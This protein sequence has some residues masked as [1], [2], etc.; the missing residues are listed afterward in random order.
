LRIPYPIWRIFEKLI[1]AITRVIDSGMFVLGPQV[2]TLEAKLAH[3]LG[4][5]GAVGV[6][7][8]TDALVLALLA[9]GVTPGDD[10][11]AGA[12][13]AAI[14]MI[15]AVPV[16]VDID[17]ETYCL[18]LDALEPARSPRTRA[19]LPVH[20]Y[21]HPANLHAIGAYARKHGISVDAGRDTSRARWSNPEVRD[22]EI[23]IFSDGPRDRNCAR[24]CRAGS[25]AVG[26]ARWLHLR[27]S[28]LARRKF[29]TG[30]E[31]HGGPLART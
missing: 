23:Y 8:G 7:C 5:S 20:L 26:S 25:A 27:P 12:M 10:N 3:R 1:G 6:A 28:R 17:P 29:R 18:D 13:V 30:S 14:R 11:T 4:V 9:G 21:G 16:L 19:I 2:E 22:A 15:G 31:H 24:W